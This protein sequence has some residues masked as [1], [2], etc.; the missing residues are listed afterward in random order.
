MT[1]KQPLNR[2]IEH[3]LLKPD[4]TLDEFQQLLDEAI[5]YNFA[6]VCVSPFMALPAV[7][8]LKEYP[9]INVCT[10]VGFPHGNIP[11][12]LKYEEAKYLVEN[13]V[14]EIDFVAN[15]GLIKSGMYENV[16]SEL[17]VLGALCKT[18]KAISKC[19]IETCYLTE[20]EK[21][22]MYRALS[23]RTAVN[24]I[25]T[26]TG[27]GTGGASTGDV[28]K[29]N[30]RRQVEISE[31]VVETGGGLIQLHDADVSS[32][33]LR[34]GEPL[35]IKAAGGISDLRTALKFIGCGADRIG[36]SASVKVMEEYNAQPTTFTEGEE[37]T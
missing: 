2:Y 34:N 10:V 7:D 3:T 21:M 20:D 13:G 5:R 31:G 37:T 14:D 18:H 1:L 29:W 35:K 30:E 12:P 26:S 27:F 11:F 16:G 24:Y 23:E 33:I 22:F 9:T 28:W 15:I 6:A 8:A 25:K 32:Y 36:M 17:E 4:A 19:I